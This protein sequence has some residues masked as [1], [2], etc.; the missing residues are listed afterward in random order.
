MNDE[1]IVTLAEQTQAA[2]SIVTREDDISVK[3]DFQIEMLYTAVRNPPSSSL[4]HSI[5]SYSLK[6]P[7]NFKIQRN[8]QKLE[9][10]RIENA[11]AGRPIM[12]GERSFRKAKTN[13][14]TMDECLL[15]QI[16]QQKYGESYSIIADILGSKTEQQVRKFFKKWHESDILLSNTR[17]LG[18]LPSVVVEESKIES[19]EVIAATESIRP[20]YDSLTFFLPTERF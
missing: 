5:L 14:W 18:K 19:I 1:D 20:Q 4:I 7:K 11:R 9:A 6:N 2:N 12:F 13:G 3:V 16:G 8:K 10:I 17:K 15:L